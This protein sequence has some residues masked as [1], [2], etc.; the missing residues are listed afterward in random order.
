MILIEFDPFHLCVDN[1]SSL[2]YYLRCVETDLQSGFLKRIVNRFIN[3]LVSLHRHIF[4][5]VK[6]VAGKFILNVLNSVSQVVELAD[7]AFLNLLCFR[8]LSEMVIL[9]SCHCL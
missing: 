4:V 1:I 3:Q 8:D 6:L 9:V 2:I 7:L 5:Y